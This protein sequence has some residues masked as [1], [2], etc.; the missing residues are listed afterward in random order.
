MARA[1]IE[2]TRLPL[3]EAHTE[4]LA[5]GIDYLYLDG[6]DEGGVAVRDRF[7]ARPELFTEMFRRGD[8]VVYA[9]RR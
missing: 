4:A 9:V 8:V 5:L 7:R 2:H 6:D 1:L 3:A